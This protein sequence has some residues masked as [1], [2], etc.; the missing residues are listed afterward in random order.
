MSISSSVKLHYKRHRSSPKERDVQSKASVYKSSSDDTTILSDK[1]RLEDESHA[2]PYSIDRSPSMGFRSAGTKAAATNFV[3]ENQTIRRKS[4]IIIH[5]KNSDLNNF[6]NVTEPTSSKN[7]VTPG[8]SDNIKTNPLDNDI[9]SM[10][11]GP[12][13]QAQPAPL[14]SCHCCPSFCAPIVNCVPPT[15]GLSPF[16]MNPCCFYNNIPAYTHCTNAY[17]LIPY[18]CCHHHNS[19]SPQLINCACNPYSQCYSQRCFYARPSQPSY[20]TMEI[21]RDE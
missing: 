1:Q 13:P 15:L 16:Q 4:P 3:K 19:H 10:S 18:N 20:L 21:P 11:Y 9:K 14:Y 6:D 17:N 12:S 7:A 2:T 5:D 8:N